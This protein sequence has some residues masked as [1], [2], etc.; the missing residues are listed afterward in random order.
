MLLHVFDI[1]F[2]GRFVCTHHPVC[3][4]RHHAEVH[5]RINMV[6]VM[7]PRQKEAPL[8]SGEPCGALFPVRV[9]LHMDE[10]PSH[11]MHRQRHHEGDSENTK[12]DS[13]CTRKS[14]EI[15]S[16]EQRRPSPACSQLTEEDPQVNVDCQT[17]AFRLIEVTSGKALTM[18]ECAMLMQSFIEESDVLAEPRGLVHKDPMADPFDERDQ[19][20][21]KAQRRD[22]NKGPEKSVSHN[23][24]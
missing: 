20:I 22:E 14:T 12:A 2:I 19:H 10:V 17:V 4:R 11:V 8:G 1:L 7:I 15:R 23:Y 3:Q 9:H 13:R 16:N 18:M 21:G 5:P 24:W 6:H